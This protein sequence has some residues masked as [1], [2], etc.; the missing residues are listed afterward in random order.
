MAARAVSLREIT[1][2]PGEA[3]WV[4]SI[5]CRGVVYEVHDAKLKRPAA[6][7]FLASRYG[8]LND[9]GSTVSL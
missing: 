7:K 1:G 6:P 3:A 8:I 4:S 5:K 9:W 2:K